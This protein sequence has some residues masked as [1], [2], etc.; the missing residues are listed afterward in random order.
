[1]ETLHESFCGTFYA[2]KMLGVSV[3]TVQGLVEKGELQA[4]KTKGG[5]RRISVKSI[6]DYQQ[7][8]GVPNAGSDMPQLRVL[9]VDD[10]ALSLEVLKSHVEKMN[11]HIDLTGMTSAME[12]MIDVS[13]LKPDILMTDLNMP[14]VD[15]FE[16][17]RTLRKNPGFSSMILVAMTGLAEDDIVSRGGLPP[18]TVTVRKPFDSKWLN[19]FFSGVMAARQAGADGTHS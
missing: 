17:M 5:H 9:L 7:L 8:H 18:H 6:R 2:A 19:G 15:G 16:L 12:A 1:M 4:W 3:G 13:G 11:L 14:G 10:D